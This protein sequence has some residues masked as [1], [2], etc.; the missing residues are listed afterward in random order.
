MKTYLKNSI[1]YQIFPRNFTKK[2][3]FKGVE[4][5]LS[6]LSDLGVDIIQTTPINLIGKVG[7]KGTL[8]SPYAIQD[9]YQINPEYGDLNDL[10]HLINAIHKS[11]MKF[12]IDI[13][14]NHTS[15]D[16][17]LLST[18]PEWFYKDNNGNFSNKVGNW[19]DVF[20][21]DYNQPGLIDYLLEVLDY[22]LSLGIDGFRFDVASLI[23]KEFF[24][25]LQQTLLV[26]YPNTILIAESVHQSFITYVRSLG[27][28]ALSDSELI[29]CGFDLLYEYNN[30]ECLENYLKTKDNYYLGQYKYGLRYEENAN[31]KET[32][33][34]RGLENHDMPRIY[35]LTH[36]K[37]IMDN[38]LAY[39]FFLK[40]P[41][42]IYMGEETKQK[43]K[44]ELFDKY[45][46]NWHFDKKW[47]ALLKTLISIKKNPTNQQLLISDVDLTKNDYLVIKNIF[48]DK[49]NAFGIFNFKNTNKS[50][51]SE[52]F[53]D[54]KYLDLISNKI[55]EIKN[56][57][58]FTKQ[59]LILIKA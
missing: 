57:K 23:K 12:V 28:N 29:E 35:N 18:H 32:L 49:S 47:F 34:I 24:I 16:S 19:S 56:K 7:R 8:G 20:D 31:P 46:V 53:I 13:V 10:K 40:G 21:L 39:S 22:Y 59:P 41:S 17:V 36:N 45:L 51:T 42:F 15:R 38:L 50:V 43:N 27:F 4:S 48:Q 30:R 54:G 58:I 33:R 55:I 5:K 2:G 3:N 52:F 9:Y 1:I 6:Y 14:F 25:K 26:K 37:N 11:G 44:I